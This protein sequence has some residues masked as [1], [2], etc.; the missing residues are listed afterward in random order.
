MNYWQKAFLLKIL[1]SLERLVGVTG[2]INLPVSDL[3]YKNGLWTYK[4]MCLLPGSLLFSLT[5]K[6]RMEAK[7]GGK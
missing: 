2:T 4:A 6:Q 3:Q 5:R 7:S 1:D